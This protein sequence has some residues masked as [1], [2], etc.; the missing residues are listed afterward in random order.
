MEFNF[1]TK[2]TQVKRALQISSSPLFKYSGFMAQ[3]FFYLFLLSWFLIAF[4]I[5]GLFLQ[6]TAIKISLFLLFIFFLLL[7][8]YLFDE[9]KVKKSKISLSLSDAISSPDNYNFAEFLSLES[10]KMIT[11]CQK[12]CSKK[13]IELSSGAVF[14]CALKESRDIQILIFRLGINIKKLQDDLKNYLEK[15]KPENSDSFQK[16][17]QEAA[18]TANTRGHNLIGEKEILVALAKEDEFFKKVLI[19]Y[20]LKEVDVENI[21]LWLDSIEDK[22]EKN[23]KFW[24]RENL[25]RLG[26]L[27]R[28]FASGFTVTLDTFSI[29]WSLPARNNAFYEIIGHE[30]EIGELEIVLTKPGSRNALIIGEDGVGKKSVVQALAQRCYSGTGLEE[31]KSKKVIELD[32]VA[33]ISQIQDQEK[34]EITLDEIFNEATTAGNIILVIDKLDNFINQKVQ[35]PGEIDISVILAKYLSLPDFQFI[36]ITSFDG[37]HRK[38]E[39]SPALLEYFT[40]VEVSEVSEVETIR[41]LQNLAVLLE[42]KYN[43]LITYPSIRQM[44][45]LSARYLPSTPFPKKAIDILEEAAAY[46]HSKKEKVLLPDHVAQII[47]DKTNIPI[48]KIEFKEKS[49]LINLENL[50]H[51]K[52]VNQVEAV[53]EISI[54]MRRARAGISSKKRPMGV[55]LFL[56]PTGVGKTETAKALAEIYFGSAEK[57]IRLDMSEFQEISDI[58]RLIG[59][60]SPVEQ[61][62]LLTTPVRENPFSLV[63][64]DEIEKS[65]PNILNLFLQVF[66]EGH[67][68]DGQGRKVIFANT[69]IIATSNAGAQMIFKAIESG[70][71]LEKDKLLDAL[72]EKAIFRPEFV[73]RFDA[74]VIFH[75]LTKENL[76]DIAQMMLGDLAKNLK[77]KEID[78]VI[79]DPLKEKIVELSYKPEFGA[80]EMRR[81]VQDKIENGIAQALLSDKIV[82]GDK[83]EINSE[84]FEIVKIS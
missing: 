26:S 69:I 74:T 77:E 50:I 42:Q 29:D 14:Y 27:G 23:K 18:K 64:L 54:A 66:D 76:M 35:R 63:L 71:K 47:S 55:F 22:I 11:A 65:H 4:S 61:Q 2:N 53:Q 37:L 78:L 75:P 81:V 38:L 25:S 79:T 28:D 48:G 83:I 1:D 43:I 41:I 10:C 70:K 44:V 21:T 49:V 17:I 52:I 31:L 73:N 46:I 84:N 58:P 13:S 59:A 12:L 20:D 30:K 33:V 5:L 82:K 80:R 56:G 39:E 72:F 68:T 57:M 62:G 6:S 3:L 45:N 40:K 9:L 67:I 60:I 32:M 7:E 15:S 51:Q 19:D 24:T 34:L 36:G 8:I 16:A